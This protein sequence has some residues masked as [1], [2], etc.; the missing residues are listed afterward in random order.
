MWGSLARECAYLFNV[1]P[2]RRNANMYIKALRSMAYITWPR[3]G[4]PSPSAVAGAGTGPR[5]PAARSRQA[6][7]L[8]L[9]PCGARPSAPRTALCARFS[10]LPDPPT[11]THH[12]PYAEALARPKVIVNDAALIVKDVALI[13]ND[14]GRRCVLAEP[15]VPNAGRAGP[16]FYADKLSAKKVTDVLQILPFSK[17]HPSCVRASGGTPRFAHAP[18]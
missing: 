6:Q 16:W 7:G 13:V 12:V 9:S 14:A 2:Q 10:R 5:P 1:W 17:R 15:C 18:D 8:D 4:R 11:Q 3:L